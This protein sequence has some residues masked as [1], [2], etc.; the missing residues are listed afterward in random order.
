MALSR[1]FFSITVA[2]LSLLSFCSNNL[3][4][5]GFLLFEQGVK[6]LGNAYAGGS[7]IAEDASTVFFNPAGIT[8]LSGTQF[9]VAAYY[10][11]TQAKFDNK[12]STVSPALPVVGGAPL[13]GGDGGDAGGGAV[14]PNFY[15]TQRITD[16]FHAGIG[17][18]VPFGLETEYSKSWVGRYHA[19]KSNVLTIDIN[20]T[21]AYRVNRWL[22]LGGGIS[23]QYIDAELTNAVDFGT[24]GFIGGGPTLP[25]TLDGF[26]ELEADDWGWR[27]NLGVLIEPTE[28]LR[29]GLSYRS[30]ID[31]NLEGDADFNIPAGAEAI[32]AGA[33]LVDTSAEADIEFPGHASLSAYWRLHPK[34]AIMADIFWTNWSTLDDIPVELGTGTDISTTLDWEDTFR[35]AFG[36]N[37]YINNNWTL[38]GGV[39]YDETPVPSARRRSPRA[40]GEDRIWTAIGL[41]YRFSDRFSFDLAYAHLFVDDP[42]IRKTGLDTEDIARGALR[43]DYDASSDVIGFQIG[44]KF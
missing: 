19:V 4:A 17:I 37:Y 15:F 34:F 36:T 41:S 2:A 20:P 1:L 44:I 9:E 40:P 32:A 6:G 12:G 21:V 30:D 3:M 31:Y 24:I 42:K 11:K 27:W 38:R 29:F 22:S 39:A 28:N 26:A 33:G 25:Q 43:G 13:T 5:G 16:K 35:Y 18:N 10:I 14:I 8:R 7:A 23:A